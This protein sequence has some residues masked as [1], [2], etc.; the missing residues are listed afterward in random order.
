VRVGGINPIEPVK[1]YTGFDVFINFMFASIR[2]SGLYGARRPHRE[3][4]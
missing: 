1:H 3:E 4:K 2:I